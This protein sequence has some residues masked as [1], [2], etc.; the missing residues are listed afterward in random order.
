MTTTSTITAK[1]IGFKANEI[2][3]LN[4]W[5][6]KTRVEQ[7][8]D[9][10]KKWL[11]VGDICTRVKSAKLEGKFSDNVQTILGCTLTNDERQYSMK[12]HDAEKT[13]TKWY[14]ETG[15]MKYNPRTIWTAFQAKDEVELSPAEKKAAKEK[16][17]AE[18]D[19][20]KLRKER[21]GADAIRAL[22][23]FRKI[24]DNAAENGNLILK[25]LE[26]LQS[27][28]AAE[29]KAIEELVKAEKV[30]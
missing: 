13:V 18:A 2:K 27:A 12:L 19:E 8:A 22:V 15:C 11:M 28:L 26:V 24:R 20:K 3:A 21:T 10:L 17:K 1:T 9:S 30:A 29:L 7:C 4:I 5:L 6:T 14:V 25:D 23:E 16:K